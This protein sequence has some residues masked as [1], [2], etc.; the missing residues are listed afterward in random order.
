M[1]AMSNR[2]IRKSGDFV[3][4]GFSAEGGCQW[5]VGRVWRSEMEVGKAESPRR[6]DVVRKLSA[7]KHRAVW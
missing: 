1:A 4:M 6:V 3:F 2:S 5:S 7:G